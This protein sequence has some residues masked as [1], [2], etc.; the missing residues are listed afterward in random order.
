M[1]AK[2]PFSADIGFLYLMG[3]DGCMKQGFLL[4]SK[5]NLNLNLSNS[6]A[7]Y[8]ES[9]AN[10]L[11]VMRRLCSTNKDYSHANSIT[12]C[13]CEHRQQLPPLTRVLLS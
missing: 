3:S 8:F 4:V 5:L 12:C 13:R 6:Q 2:L 9:K 7:F 1:K 11:E 10:Y